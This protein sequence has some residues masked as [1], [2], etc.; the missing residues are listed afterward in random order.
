M[1]TYVVGPGLNAGY[2]VK[3]NQKFLFRGTEYSTFQKRIENGEYCGSDD[4]PFG[5]STFVAANINGAVA[6]CG[7]KLNNLFESVAAICDDDIIIK[8]ENGIYEYIGDRPILLAIEHEKYHLQSPDSAEGTI[9]TE[10]IS[11]DDIVIIKTEKDLLNVLPSNHNLED[12]AI[13][14]IKRTVGIFF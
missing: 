10:K 13:Q 12:A 2:V 8:N 9:I 1:R 5:P 3:I 7:C 11:L 4:A 6:Y 14:K